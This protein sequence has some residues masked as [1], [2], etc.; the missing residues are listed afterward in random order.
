[1]TISSSLFVT[2]GTHWRQS[3]IRHGR[4]CRKSTLQSRPSRFGPR[5]HWRQSR[6]PFDIRV[7]KIT[8]FRQYRPSWTCSTLATMST[9]T[10]W[11]QNAFKIALGYIPLWG[12][13][14]PKIANWRFCGLWS[15]I[16]KATAVRFGVR[17]RTWDSFPPQILYKKSLEGVLAAYRGIFF[18]TKMPHF[19]DCV[20]TFLKPQWWN[21]GASG[22]TWDP[23]N[24]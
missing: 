11:R 17:L 1:M 21:F 14:I 4:L 3:Q 12:K 8:H 15:H 13:F 5:T 10:N 9:A 18:L 2:A 6:K 23:P 20:P 7:T 22:R 16:F 24:A 19:D